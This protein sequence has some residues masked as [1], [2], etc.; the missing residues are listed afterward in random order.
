MLASTLLISAAP[1]PVVVRLCFGRE[2]P[3]GP[4]GPLRSVMGA[5]VDGF[6]SRVLVA[7]IGV[8]DLLEERKEILNVGGRLKVNGRER[9]G[10]VE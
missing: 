2:I 5:D 6:L 3:S 7:M 10:I 1:K 4:T 9:L 8:K